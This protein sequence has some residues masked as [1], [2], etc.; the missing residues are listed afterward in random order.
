MTVA[1]SNLSATWSNTANIY[2]AIGMNVSNTGANN[3]SSLL[4]LSINGNNVFRISVDGK[5]RLGA[6]NNFN[7]ANPSVSGGAYAERIFNI[8][9]VAPTIKLAAIDS[10]TGIE[11]VRYNTAVNAVTT[12]MAVYG[13]AN[14]LIIQDRTT[15]PAYTLMNVTNTLITFSRDTNITGN[16]TANVINA[17]NIFLSGTDIASALNPTPNTQVFL[18]DGTWYKPNGTWSKVIIKLWGGGGAGSNASTGGGG[19]D[20]NGGG[21][22]AGFEKE[23]FYYELGDTGTVTIGI[24]GQTTRANGGNSTFSS[25]GIIFTAYGG[26][27]G[28][29]QGTFNGGGGA[30][31]LGSGTRDGGRGGGG[32]GASDRGDNY[33]A[34]DGIVYGGGGGGS[35]PNTTTAKAASHGVGGSSIYG[36]GGGGA[37]NTQGGSTWTQRV[38]GGSLFGGAGGNGA[39]NTANSQPG[40]FPAGG[41]GGG[42]SA[43]AP[44]TIFGKGANGYCV[45]ITY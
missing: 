27:G 14:S 40:F 42:S 7:V 22:G 41:G 11:L 31:M 9:D 24:G 26:Q 25:N 13:T 17:T 43:S 28:F 10:D 29:Q 23:F 3:R 35:S 36:G 2:N 4:S 32:A 45:V 15:G 18:T 30:G 34:G 16:L 39:T 19:S 6:A 37:G 33:D 44:R 20:G 5:L 1:I 12:F 8:V 38:G 21:G